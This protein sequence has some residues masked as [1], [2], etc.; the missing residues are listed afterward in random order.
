MLGPRKSRRPPPRRR[1]KPPAGP[2]AAAPIGAQFD[3]TARVLFRDPR[4]LI[5]DKP[6]GLPVHAGPRGGATL[7]DHLDAL[8]FGYQERP[9]LAHRLDRDTSGCLVLG[10]NRKA[11]QRL[12]RLFSEGRVEKTY[13]A[14]TLGAPA[15][16][17]GRIDLPLAKLNAVKGWR[18]IA[19]PGGQPAV[20]EWRV[21]GRGG[22]LAWIECR[23][24]TGRTH[25]IRV[26]LAEIGCPILGDPLYGPRSG[27]SRS[28]PLHLHARRILLPLDPARAPV[29]AEAPLPAAL[30]PAFAACG[31]REQPT[32]EDPQR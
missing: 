23:P 31:W 32:E 18:M 4:L 8:R 17:S 30:Q 14:V 5:L 22:G 21:L 13:W 7:V 12:G 6:A 9:Q 15:E 2:G 26:H 25:Q 29:V 10:R 24:L 3:M 1:P 16:D 27:E 11:L 28:R 19:G 20:T